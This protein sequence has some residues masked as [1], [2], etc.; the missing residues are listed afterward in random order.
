MYVQNNFSKMFLAGSIGLRVKTEID[1][2]VIDRIRFI[3]IEQKLSQADLAYCIGVSK[4]FI[5]NVENPRYRAKYNLS[6]LNEIA[7]VLNCPIAA[8][9]PT[10]PL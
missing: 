3:R 6:H 4:S 10:Q 2:Y 5:A 8:L 9:L 7:K 1:L